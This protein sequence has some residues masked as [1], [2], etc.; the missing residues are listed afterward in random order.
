MRME[1]AILE[2]PATDALLADEPALLLDAIAGVDRSIASLLAI[3]ARMIDQSR[4]LIEATEAARPTSRGPSADRELAR[5]LLVSELAPLLR[6]P[7]NSAARLVTESRALVEELPATLDALGRGEF[8]Y[9]HAQVVIENADSLPDEEARR[10]FEQTVLPA[11]RTLTAARFGERARRVR[12]RMH[13]ESLAARRAKQFDRRSV[14]VDPAR[15]GMAWLTA[16]LPAETAV[17]IDDRLDQL[18]GALRDPADPRT[19]AQLRADAFCDL[20]V[21]GEVPSGGGARGLPRGI[22]AR[23]LVTVPVLTLLRLDDE[24]ASL[25]GY[26][27]IPADVAGLIAAEAPSFTRLLTHPETGTVLSVG[28]DRYTV[29]ADMRLWL[30]LRDETCRAPGCGR[31][32]ATCDVDHSRSWKGGGETAGDNLAHLCRGDHVRKHRL[33]WRMEHLPGGVLRWT[34]PMGRAYLTEPSAILRT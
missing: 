34:S 23:V 20:M 28:R 18:A 7:V 31:R 26:G 2:Q 4:G 12:E 10:D 1:T 25:E 14:A 24:P 27:P 32:A 5:Q 17:A 30:R 3:R 8:S 15:D 16:Y 33:G 9:R 21:S 11:A 6:I 13:P 22:R 19:F 29:P